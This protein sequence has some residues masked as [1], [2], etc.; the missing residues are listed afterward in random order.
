MINFFLLGD[1]K[2]CPES[3][4]GWRNAAWWQGFLVRR[5]GGHVWWCLQSECCKSSI[6][7][8]SFYLGCKEGVNNLSI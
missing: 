5:R 6:E 8:R 7:E 1:C 3:S 2:G 4:H